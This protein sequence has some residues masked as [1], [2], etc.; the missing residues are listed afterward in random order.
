MKGTK[1]AVILYIPLF[2]YL[3]QH[4]CKHVMLVSAYFGKYCKKA[5]F[6]RY[7]L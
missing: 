4:T 2:V 7:I 1:S 5:P 3:W 6:H